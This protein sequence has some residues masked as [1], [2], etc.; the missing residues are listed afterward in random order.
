MDKKALTGRYPR[1]A[2][3]IRALPEA[4]V[5]M[6]LPV[7]FPANRL[8]VARNDPVEFVYYFLQGELMIFNETMDGKLSTWM[9]VTSPTV[10]SDIEV[11]AGQEYYAANVSTVTECMA[12]RLASADFAALLHRDSEFLWETASL[13]AKKNFSR[14]HSRG[15][16]V[17]LPALD[18]T[19]LFLL[20]RYTR[21]KEPP[22]G[23]L[24]LLHTRS[25]LASEIA[26][27]QKTLDRCLFQL[28]DEGYLT[29]VK[30]KVHL[31]AAQIEKMRAR[32]QTG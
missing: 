3:V 21:E 23:E 18:K 6:A 11:L 20:E 22:G 13:M 5:S 26:I 12:L 29:I 31:T 27:G 14:S 1:L 19:A 30:G 16:S 9:T 28:R 32:W 7:C 4:L 24:V 8:L 17:L 10:I 25:F 15:I 2:G